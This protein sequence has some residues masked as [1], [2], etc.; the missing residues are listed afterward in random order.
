MT[1]KFNTEFMTDHIDMLHKTS[2]QNIIKKLNPNSTPKISKS[3]IDILN[4][5]SGDIT[6]KEI[7]VLKCTII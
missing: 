5:T 6:S 1:D 2:G 4:E 7:K 3:S